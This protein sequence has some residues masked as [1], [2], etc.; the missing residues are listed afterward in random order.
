VEFKCEKP[1][2]WLVSFLTT[3]SHYP[4]PRFRGRSGTRLIGQCRPCEISL[5]K[6]MRYVAIYRGGMWEN[7]SVNV[8]TRRTCELRLRRGSLHRCHEYLTYLTP[9]TSR[10][11]NYKLHHITSLSARSVGLLRS[12]RLVRHGWHHH[13]SMSEIFSW[14]QICR[15]WV[16]AI[17][18][19]INV[20]LPFYYK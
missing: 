11:M 20:L 16:F 7:V 14:R 6:V 17:L 10:V 13:E 8:E 9:G 5:I 4:R 18:G 19:D 15:Y 2:Q 12:L 3:W 1:L